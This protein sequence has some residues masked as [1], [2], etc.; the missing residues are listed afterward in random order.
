MREK[1]LRLEL[2]KEKKKIR[3]SRFHPRMRLTLTCQALL[4][5]S[6]LAVLGPCVSQLTPEYFNIARGKKITATATCGY[7]L[8]HDQETELFCKLATVPGKFGIQGLECD[9]CDRKVTS[10]VKETKD[11]RI[12]YAIDGTERWWQSPPLS[13]GQQYNKINITIDL[14]RVRGFANGYLF[15]LKTARDTRLLS[16]MFPTRFF[17]VSR[18]TVSFQPLSFVSIRN[19]M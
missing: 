18:S 3:G 14:G 10:G 9:H 1:R 4:L 7:D 19:K 5:Y 2:S 15:L 17:L 12:A 8:P 16:W 6:L 13:R 11:H